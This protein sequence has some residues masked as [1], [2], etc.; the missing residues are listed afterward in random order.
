MTVSPQASTED[1]QT[2]AF[3]LPCANS[4]LAH[5]AGGSRISFWHGNKRRR[6]RAAWQTCKR[7]LSQHNMARRRPALHKTYARGGDGAAN[8]KNTTG[9]QR[10]IVRHA[11]KRRVL[12]MASTARAALFLRATASSSHI[13]IVAGSA[14]ITLKHAAIARHSYRLA[15]RTHTRAK[16]RAF[17]F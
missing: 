16:Q 1:H 17:S 14:V 12:N 11:I 9:S 8:N 2:L 7:N 4:G 5:Q 3:L 10:G 15:C 6:W 13:G